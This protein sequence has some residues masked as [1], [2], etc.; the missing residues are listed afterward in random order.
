MGEIA[1]SDFSSYMS[2]RVD[3]GTHYLL[4]PDVGLREKDTKLKVRVMEKN[5]SK[6]KRMERQK[7]IMILLSNIGED[8]MMKTVCGGLKWM[9]KTKQA[10]GVFGISLQIMIPY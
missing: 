6:K 4:C 3:G 10:T 2:V 7:I 1:T 5:D 9:G 8:L